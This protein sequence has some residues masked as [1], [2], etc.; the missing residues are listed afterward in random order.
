MKIKTNNY[1][2]QVFGKIIFIKTFHAW[3]A[4]INHQ[5]KDELHQLVEDIFSDQ[6]WVMISDVRG[7]G[8]NTPDAEESSEEMLRQ[9]E[10]NF[11][12]H[13]AFVVGGSDI[14]KW[15]L[16]K[17]LKNNQHFKMHIVDKMDEAIDWIEQNGF[18]VDELK[19]HL[20]D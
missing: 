16:E 5:F 19:R 4:R 11:P 15:Q 12:T 2:I 9:T 8:L 18:Q 6:N 3:D 14:K 7:W 20:S 10:I 1:S 17:M 13:V